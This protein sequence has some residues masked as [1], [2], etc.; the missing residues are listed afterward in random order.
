M[1]DMIDINTIHQMNLDKRSP[2]AMIAMNVNLRHV[3]VYFGVS[4]V[5]FIFFVGKIITLQDDS[6]CSLVE[7]RATVLGFSPGCPWAQ[8]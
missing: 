8:D 3:L 7:H 2:E 1:H 5:F 6:M 4:F